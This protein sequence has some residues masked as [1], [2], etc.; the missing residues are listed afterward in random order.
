MAAGVG[1][2]GGSGGAGRSR[3]P[4]W[5][6]RAAAVYLVA[7][8]GATLVGLGLSAGVSA[9]MGGGTRALVPAVLGVSAVASWTPVLVV[10]W[11]LGVIGAQGWG[12]AVFAVTA[13]R[14]LT[15]VGALAL[16]TRSLGLSGDEARAGAMAILGGVLVLLVADVGV[17]AW[18]LNGTGAPGGVGGVGVA[19]GE[20]KLREE[21]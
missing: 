6:A 15:A 1:G 2:T 3:G 20:G 14:T 7:L 13:A 19:G 5:G 21:P 8:V 11:W 4:V 10:L 18:A 12:L 9:W 17:A 16:V